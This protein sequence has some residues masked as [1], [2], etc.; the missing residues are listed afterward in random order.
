MDVCVLLS[1]A[2]DEIA[3]AILGV[4][5]KPTFGL[6]PYSGIASGDAM[7]DHA[8]PLARTVLDIAHC[9]DAI[10]G[11]DGMDDRSL[12]SPKH[13]STTYA[14]TLQEAP[15]KLEGFKVGIL[16][17]GFGHSIVDPAVRSTVMSAARKYEELGAT[18]EEISLPDHLNGP[19]VWTIQSRVAGSM[20]LLGQAHGRRGL[21]L[22]ELERE[23][24]PWTK[25]SFQRAFPTTQNVMINGLYLMS[26][27]PEL[28]AK[29][30]NIGRK[31]RD[32][33]EET[34]EKYDV[35]AMPTTPIVAPKHGTRGLPMESIKPS[36]GLTIN[37]A[38]FNLTGHP[39]MSI[40]VGFAPAKEDEKVR[41]PVGMEIVG[42]LWQESKV[43]RAGHAWETHFNWKEMVSNDQD[44]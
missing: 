19:A 4:G 27:F 35:V 33:Y 24:L 10:S 25:E 37:T 22:T 42:G 18:V 3:N 8:G 13:G 5:L 36:M 14:A 21:G 6:V 2:S 15:T 1:R 40:P 41:L 39:A 32:L 34:F 43:L 12:G 31:L 29:A 7:D 20:N 26:R 23:R 30:N 28:Y 38:V 11:Y 17:E 9:L 16:T 44:S